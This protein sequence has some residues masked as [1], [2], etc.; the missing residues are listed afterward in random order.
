MAVQEQDGIVQSATLKRLDPI[1][2]PGEI[3][4]L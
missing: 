4:F 1:V 2:K 3:T